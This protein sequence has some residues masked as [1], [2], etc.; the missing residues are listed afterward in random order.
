MF[1]V[2]FALILG[3]GSY[4]YALEKNFGS[5]CYEAELGEDGRPVP[6]LVVVSI[7][8]NE[9]FKPSSKHFWTLDDYSL[10][11]NR[12]RE[13]HG[14][15]FAATMKYRKDNDKENGWNEALIGE[16]TCANHLAA[17]RYVYRN[18]YSVLVANGIIDPFLTPEQFEEVQKRGAAAAAEVTTEPKSGESIDSE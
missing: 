4:S 8:Q 6:R 10:I 5:E 3:L 15:M 9:K 17:G 2:F 14:C 1:Q 11:H 12:C 16:I 13:N 7:P 18:S